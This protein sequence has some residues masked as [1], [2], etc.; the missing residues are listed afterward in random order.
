MNER[1]LGFPAVLQ[2]V[3]GDAVG[4]CRPARLLGPA[5]EAREP[6]RAVD[7]EPAHRARVHVVARRAADLPDAVVGLV[8]APR[9]RIDD[10]L[11][12]QVMGLGHVPAGDGELVGQLD[13]RAEDVE[14]HL[15]RSGVADAHRAAAGVSRNGLDHGLGAGV[16][17]H[18]PSTAGAGARRPARPARGASM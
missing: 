10:L 15:L 2:H 4:E 13:D 18:A 9:D 6:Q 8:P 7:R 16:A 1:D 11:D 12:E 5:G 17:A 3:R 14:L